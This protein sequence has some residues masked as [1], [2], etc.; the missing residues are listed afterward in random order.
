MPQTTGTHW[1][2]PDV[3]EPTAGCPVFTDNAICDSAPGQR[4]VNRTGRIALEDRCDRG[5]SHQRD[6]LPG[7]YIGREVNA[8]HYSRRPDDRREAE[9]RNRQV[10]AD[11]RVANRNR[12]RGGGVP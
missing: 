10:R 8:Q 4:T 1:R 5:R 7:E 9:Q 12:Q 11:A 6:S 3:A 2:K